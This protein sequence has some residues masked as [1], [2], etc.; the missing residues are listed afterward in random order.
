MSEPFS[1][2][3]PEAESRPADRPEPDPNVT[4]QFCLEKNVLG[5]SGCKYC[6][7]LTP[8]IRNYDLEPGAA[9]DPHK[10]ERCDE[11]RLLGGT[12]RKI[13]EANAEA[14]LRCSP[15]PALAIARATRCTL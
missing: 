1:A 3:S 15:A 2:E 6:S 7:G 14:V 13:S 4:F 8:G 5:I 9:R 10:M 12:I 11:E